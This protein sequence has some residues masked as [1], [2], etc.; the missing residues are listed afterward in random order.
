M[1]AAVKERYIGPVFI[2]G[3]HFQVKVA[4]FKEDS[5]REIGVLQS[6]IKESVDAGF[7]NID[8]DLF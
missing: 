6:L 7:Y 1:A 3:D 8:V 2:Q 5:N 4:K